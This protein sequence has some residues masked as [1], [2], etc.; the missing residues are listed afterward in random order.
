MAEVQRQVQEEEAVKR[1]K[2]AD[3]EAK[4]RSMRLIIQD[5]DVNDNEDTQ[6]MLQIM[7]C[8]HSARQMKWPKVHACLLS[9]CL[10]QMMMLKAL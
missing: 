3:D 4:V 2:K 7:K 8:Y 10:I 1:S 9:K 6:K 5:R